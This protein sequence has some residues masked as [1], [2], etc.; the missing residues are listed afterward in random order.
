MKLLLLHDFQLQIRLLARVRRELIP[1]AAALKFPSTHESM[2]KLWRL[3]VKL[4]SSLLSS[5]SGTDIDCGGL[6]SFQVSDIEGN[7]LRF[8]VL[9]GSKLFEGLQVVHQGDTVTEV[10]GGS[11]NSIFFVYFRLRRSQALLLGIL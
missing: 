11:I 10:H 6:L 3:I 9:K 1:F 7:W 2:T 4:L 8:E 5:S